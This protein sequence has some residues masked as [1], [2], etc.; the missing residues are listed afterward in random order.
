MTADDYENFDEETGWDRRDF[1]RLGGA[2]L[3]A[4]TLFDPVES[5]AAA[6]RPVRKLA[7][8]NTHT[9]ER[10]KAEYWVKGRYQK[11]ALKAINRVM[12]DHRTGSVH[13]MDP[14]LLDL[15][16]AMQS[17]LGAKGPFHLVS[18]YRSPQ[19]N[20]ALR[21][22]D[23]SGVA[24]RSFHVQGKA[25]DIRMPN[26]PLSNLYKVALRMRGGGVGCYPESNFVHVDVG[27]VRRW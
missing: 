27:P 11:D 19:T 8:L 5:L 15:M 7:F 23:S 25:V 14:R 17:R 24:R 2:A 26:L 1:L 4:A 21:E 13:K 9:G 16:F 12:R 6:Q 10:I 3:V 20:A 18:A 22:S